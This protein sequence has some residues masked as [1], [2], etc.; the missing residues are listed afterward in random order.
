MTVPA[1]DARGFA[2]ATPAV[3]EKFHEVSAA[4]SPAAVTIS[5][6]ADQFNKLLL[7]WKLQRFQPDFFCV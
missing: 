7:A 6:R 4:F 1:I 3:G 2:L 5:D